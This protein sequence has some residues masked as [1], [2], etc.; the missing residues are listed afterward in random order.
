MIPD[1]SEIKRIVSDEEQRMLDHDAANADAVAQAMEA[2][3][4]RMGE[5]TARKS[6]AEYIEEASRKHV[7]DIKEIR[8]N[9]SQVDPNFDHLAPEVE[10]LIEAQQQRHE[11][12]EQAVAD[13]INQLAFDIY[14]NNREVGWYKDFEGL[15]DKPFF[16]LILLGRL[17]LQVT[18]LS[19]AAEG[20]R[21]NLM[22]DK[23]PHR[24]MEE[25]EMADAIIRILDHCGYRG[26][27]V[28]GA[29]MEKRRFNA[30]RPDH[31][32]ENRSGENGKKC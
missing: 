22:D 24:T 16:P 11:A 12:E 20:I 25:V 21:K 5:A 15:E 32:L 29:I 18:E 27:D 9:L 26:L 31:K 10:V 3:K 1:Y 23:L 7:G 14:Q 13:A 28:G 19:E 2:L 6:D 17:M 8:D 4:A 30:V